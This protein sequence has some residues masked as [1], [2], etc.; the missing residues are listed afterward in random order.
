MTNN[1]PDQTNVLRTGSVRIEWNW[2]V[3]ESIDLGDFRPGSAGRATLKGRCTRCWGRLLGRVDDKHVLTGIRC[4][5]CGRLV[6]GRDAEAVGRQM[7]H[8]GT[9]NMLNM[10]LGHV[11]RYKEDS[12]FVYKVFPEIAPPPEERF[13]KHVEMKAAAGAKRDWLTRSGFPA[14]S[15]GYFLLQARVLISGVE[16]TPREMT[17]AQFSDF[18]LNDDGSA[19]VHISKEELGKHSTAREYEFLKRL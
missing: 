1:S 8:E 16:R 10:G 2:D 6:Q 7:S 19:T 5:V 9:F 12:K 11:P 3:E 15:A 13:L 4:R 18:D 17:V 14:G